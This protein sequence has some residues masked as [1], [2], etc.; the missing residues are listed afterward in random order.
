MVHGCPVHS[1][2]RSLTLVSCSYAPV[3]QSEPVLFEQQHMF[4]IFVPLLLY[5]EY[6]TM[7][8]YYSNNFM[9][10]RRTGEEDE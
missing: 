7:I 10:F 4:V 9:R 6:I 1:N 8:K 2:I 5:C 3:Q